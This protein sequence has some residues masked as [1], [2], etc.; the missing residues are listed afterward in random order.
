MRPPAHS[1]AVPD[2]VLQRVQLGSQYKF[3]S[4]EVG[5]IHCVK[6]EIPVSFTKM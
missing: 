1:S 3:G 4:V 6:S 2:M 5:E